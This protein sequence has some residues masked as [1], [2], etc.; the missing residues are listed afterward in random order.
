M[1]QSGDGESGGS[2]A[3][4]TKN[5]SPLA[6]IACPVRTGRFRLRHNLLFGIEWRFTGVYTES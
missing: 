6:L 4:R 5:F 1:V 3:E 2:A